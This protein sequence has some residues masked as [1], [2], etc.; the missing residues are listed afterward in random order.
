[1]APRADLLGKRI[2]GCGFAAYVTELVTDAAV[3]GICL[4]HY[5]AGMVF[6]PLSE[7]HIGQLVGGDI[8]LLGENLPVS[9]GLVEHIY[10]VRVLW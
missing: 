3:G 10:K 7:C 6:S 9:G 4:L 5:C 8:Q 2:A 1:M